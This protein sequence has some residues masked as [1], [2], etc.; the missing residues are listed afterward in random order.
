MDKEDEVFKEQLDYRFA[1]S[2][3]IERV[4]MA[5]GD[6][7]RYVNAV[8]QLEDLLL[9]YLDE[10]ARVELAKVDKMIKECESKVFSYS[11]DELCALY[12]MRFRILIELMDRK[13]LL[14]VGRDR[15]DML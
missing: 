15:E 10:R 6:P 13:G 12:R 14:L 4:C 11:E 7:V 5:I 2:R 3:Q 8:C 1:L 9:P